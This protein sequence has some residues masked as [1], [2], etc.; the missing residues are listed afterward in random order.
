MLSA[1]DKEIFPAQATKLNE[2]LVKQV[3]CTQLVEPRCL[4]KNCDVEFW[5]SVVKM[6]FL[7]S[8]DAYT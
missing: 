7:N 2:I 1:V 6:G 5:N 8:H 4:P 3:L